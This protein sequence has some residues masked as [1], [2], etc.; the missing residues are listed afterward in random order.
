[1]RVKMFHTCGNAWIEVVL[2]RDDTPPRA[3]CGVSDGRATDAKIKVSGTPRATKTFPPCGQIGPMY[4]WHGDLI[5]MPL[6]ISATHKKPA[7]DTD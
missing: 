2:D 1:M 7:I 3:T 6:K 5:D 4:Q